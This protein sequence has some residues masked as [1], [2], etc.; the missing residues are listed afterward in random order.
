MP[1]EFNL[2]NIAV[3]E[4]GVG[5]DGDDGWLLARVPVDDAVQ[6]ALRDMAVATWNAMQDD[7]DDP[8]PYQPSE[9]HASNE[10]LRLVRGNNLE[11]AMRQI[12]DAENLPPDTAAL[13]EPAEIVCYFAR[14]LDTHNR[15][16]IALRR[17][18]QF[19]GILKSRLVRVDDDSL[20]I[21]HDPIFKLDNDFDVLIDAE[22]T[23]IWRPAAFEF[24]GGLKQAVLDAVPEN[25]AAIRH[26]VTFVD[27]T[28]I[29]TFA[30]THSRAARYLASIRTQALAGMEPQRLMALC[31]RAEVPFEHVA[32]M[33]RVA[34]PH[35]M[36]FLEVLDRRR[37]DLELVPGTRERFRATSRLKLAGT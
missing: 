14:F 31:D 7:T 36:D 2:G 11:M 28:S 27:F 34:A 33:V 18:S 21:V 32:G 9:K 24:L 8:A 13:Q 30:A 16:L 37:Y 12:Y 20:S 1:L 25:V 23:H 6:V 4:F 19:K 10:Y 5:R 17:A 26:D 35:V 22:H 29:Q 15:R 3:T